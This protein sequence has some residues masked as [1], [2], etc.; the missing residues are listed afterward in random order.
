MQE[1]GG[2]CGRKSLGKGKLWA[3]TQSG[4]AS[5][6]ERQIPGGWIA[7]GGK[8]SSL[9][10]KVQRPHRTWLHFCATGLSSHC[11]EPSVIQLALLSAINIALA[12]PLSLKGF[13]YGL[14]M[15]VS[16]VLKYQLKWHLLTGSFSDQPLKGVF[17]PLFSVISHCLFPPKLLNNLYLLATYF[18]ISLFALY[19]EKISENA[20]LIHHWILEL[21][22]AQGM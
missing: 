9:L 21:G 8:Y 14:C 5:E 11:L 7:W 20:C 19:F 3:G 18:F 1:W 10:I 4:G 15:A 12:V 2:R 22:I 16:F 6:E 17:P 13:T